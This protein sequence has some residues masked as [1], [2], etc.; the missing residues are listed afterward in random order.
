MVS[1]LHQVSE[2]LRERCESLQV[3]ILEARVFAL[4]ERDGAIWRPAEKSHHK[5]LRK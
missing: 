2:G 1:G 5:M 4:C 3:E